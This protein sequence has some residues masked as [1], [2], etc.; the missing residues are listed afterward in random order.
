M[1]SVA[2]HGAG[3]LD[4]A[5][6]ATAPLHADEHAFAALVH[7]GGL[8]A[9]PA[10]ADP[11]LAAGVALLRG[12][13]SHDFTRFDGN[14]DGD[15]VDVT[16][17][18]VLSPTSLETYARCPRRWFFAQALRLR[19]MDR[20]EEIHRLPPRDR[21]TL[22][23][24]AL[25]RFFDDAIA[26]DAV[27]APGR[28]W[29]EVARDRLRAITD[30]ECD[31]VEARGITGHPRWWAHDRA[32][33]HRV[34]Q[35]VLD[36]DDEQREALGTVPVAVELTFGRQGLPPLAVDLGDG[37][38]ILLA[39]QADRVDAGAIG[40]GDGR[41][42][43]WDYKYSGTH[44]FEDLDRPD[45]DGGDPLAGGTKIQLVAYGMAALGSPRLDGVVGP[46]AEVQARYWFLKPPATN[47]H[48]GYPVT[49][50]LRE[51]FRRVLRVL[52]DGIGSG[53]FPARPGEYQ[54][55]R[56]NFDHCTWCDFDSIC[57]R[58]RDEEWER[59]RAH[60]SLAA[61]RGLAE[62]GSAWVLDEAAVPR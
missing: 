39:G 18:G 41:V 48:I 17:L 21:G 32:E 49:D 25:E 22:A 4:V 1:T 23:H 40:D 46:D 54:Y 19:A 60:P 33:I 61:V 34:L 50:E 47:R 8:D 14:L 55:H 51:R 13:R 42:V 10:G 27:P 26:G 31:A 7:A 20:P 43:V 62:A 36:G 45:A 30:E 57:P 9:H 58:D 53:R 52:A 24:L 37:R 15:G 16:S 44:G 11:V 6:G 28:R 35:R 38:S 2:S 29:P 3:L 5:R 56:G 59:V 12:R